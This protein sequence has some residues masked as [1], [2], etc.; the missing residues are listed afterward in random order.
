MSKSASGASRV[1]DNP[2]DDSLADDVM[3]LVQEAVSGRGSAACRPAEDLERERRE[4]RIFLEAMAAGLRDR[5]AEHGIKILKI[6]ADGV[7]EGYEVFARDNCGRPYQVT[8]TYDDMLG[9]M[10]VVGDEGKVRACIGHVGDLILKARQRY[11]ERM[12]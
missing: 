1:V 10:G 3:D 7:G 6:A 4:E 2:E 12:Q 11:F 5:L 9:A 8:A